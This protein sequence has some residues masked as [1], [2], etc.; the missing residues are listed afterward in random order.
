MTFGPMYLEAGR[1][2]AGGESH[3]AQLECSCHP[4]LEELQ[5]VGSSRFLGKRSDNSCGKPL[6]AREKQQ[7]LPEYFLHTGVY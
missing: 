6:L 1:N 7:L 4:H 5:S 3:G 2:R